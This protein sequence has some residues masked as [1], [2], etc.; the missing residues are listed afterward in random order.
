MSSSTHS[1]IVSLHSGVTFEPVGVVTN[2]FFDD[3]NNQVRRVLTHPLIFSKFCLASLISHR[4]KNPLHIHS[5]LF[6]RDTMK[7]GRVLSLIFAQFQTTFV[8]YLCL[9]LTNILGCPLSYLHHQSFSPAVPQ[10][11]VLFRLCPLHGVVKTV[12]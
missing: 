9:K 1:L 10:F 4:L 8:P 11:F 3:R 5:L 7:M 12:P 2:V 6:I